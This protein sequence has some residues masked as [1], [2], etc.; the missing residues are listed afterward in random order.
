MGLL[1]VVC[2]GGLRVYAGCKNTVLGGN[3][4]RRK[5]PRKAEVATSKDAN[6]TINSSNPRC[7][8]RAVVT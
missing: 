4:L 7:L 8:L 2:N 1:Q 5:T 6:S 3:K